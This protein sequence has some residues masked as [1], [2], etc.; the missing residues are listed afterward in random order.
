MKEIYKISKALTDEN[1]KDIMNELPPVYFDALGKK[2]IEETKFVIALEELLLRFR[3]YYGTENVCDIVLFKNFGKYSIEISVQGERRDYL[4]CD[5]DIKLSYDILSR[6]EV[7]PRY[8]YSHGK[9]GRNRLIWQSV[10]KSK[11]QSAA[12]PI[13]IAAVLAVIS[14]IVI[15]F[16][17]ASVH[18]MLT[19]D[20]ITPVFTK[21]TMIISALATP[22][23][24]FAVIGGIVGIGDV[25]S[26]GKIGSKILTRMA[27]SYAIA[28]VFA[29]VGCGLVYGISAQSALAEGNSALGSVVQLVLDIIPDNLLVPFTNDNDL[30]V[31][32]IAVFVGITMLILG[33]QLPRINEAV[34]EGSLLINKMM[35]ICCKLL[36]L[37]VFF[38]VTNLIATSKA[39][40]FISI[41]KM[42]AAYLVINLAFLLCMAIRARI[43]TGVPLKYIIKKQLATLM[44]NITTASQ[45]AALP[46]NMKCCKDKFGIDNKLVDFALPLGIVIYM[47]S[48]AIFLAL[49]AIGLMEVAGI[50]I[51]LGI[52]IRTVIMGT[53][54]AIAAPPIPGSA[55]VVFPILFAACGIPAEV[56]PLAIIFGTILTNVF[57]SSNGYNIQLEL[58]MTAKKLN[59]ID[60]R[61]YRES[62][63]TMK[64][65][66]S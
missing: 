1:I 8:V 15:N 58:L 16:L 2:A 29:A 47:P 56:Y 33:N 24:F 57:P 63:K 31:I 14:G 51:T 19:D 18:T 43:V 25:R 21:M 54:V 3:D 38:G 12:I 41:G 60:D 9:V 4:P 6:L 11:K 5:E 30:Q 42:L 35:T 32:V 20:F 27:G 65:A 55:L 50:P 37:V 62:G 45:V 39:E 23:V 64:K 48:G 17:P 34:K 10:S 40:Q 13:I 36:P 22:L 49:T 28:G 46:E 7:E 61:L 52:L 26:F 44:I 53:I 66:R 59:K